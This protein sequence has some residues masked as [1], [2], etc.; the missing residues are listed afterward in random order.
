MDFY[1]NNMLLLPLLALHLLHHRTQVMMMMMIR[2]TETVA[3][4]EIRI[5]MSFLDRVLGNIFTR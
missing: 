4:N 1:T 5:I 3:H 2:R